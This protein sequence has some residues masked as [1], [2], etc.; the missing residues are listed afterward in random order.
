MLA[1]GV[2]DRAAN[3]ARVANF[4]ARRRQERG[5]VA[6]NRLKDPDIR[7]AVART[8]HG[9]R[10]AV[11]L[12]RHAPEFGGEL[13]DLQV[14]AGL[15]VRRIIEELER[16]IGARRRHAASPQYERAFGKSE[17]AMPDGKCARA[18]KRYEKLVGTL[19]NLFPPADAAR[20][21]EVLTTLCVDDQPIATAHIPGVA[22]ALQAIAVAFELTTARKLPPVRRSSQ[23]QPNRVRR[24]T[25]V[26]KEHWLTC[27]RSLSPGITDDELEHRWR[28]HQDAHRMA[29]AIADR[30]KLRGEK[31][32]R[33]A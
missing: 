1:S 32:R 10:I 23:P 8:L 31:A 7:A 21:L 15:T 3:A 16:A 20:A 29:Y 19:N 28:A 27:E 30:A 2:A 9:E 22:V 12:L 24:A 14:E 11:A 4:R 6:H 5:Q 13:T 18:Q 26:V 25:N 17:I 33:R